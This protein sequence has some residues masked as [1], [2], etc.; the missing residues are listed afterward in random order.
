[1]IAIK[2]SRKNFKKKPFDAPHFK[3]GY[4]FGDSK[5]CYMWAQ[6]GH[7]NSN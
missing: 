2:V 7:Q 4:R 3:V 5:L 1:M 6:I